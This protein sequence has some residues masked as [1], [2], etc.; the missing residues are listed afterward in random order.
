V[1]GDL[2]TFLY[3]PDVM[4]PIPLT[5]ANMQKMNGGRVGSSP[6]GQLH[7]VLSRGN[8]R[9][10]GGSELIQHWGVNGGDVAVQARHVETLATHEQ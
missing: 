9:L 4:F 10:E 6:W 8:D 2:V 3:S 1:L 5:N 7:G